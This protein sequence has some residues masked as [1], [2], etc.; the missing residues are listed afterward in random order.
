MG[1]LR[2]QCQQATFAT[3][4]LIGTHRP[5]VEDN[6]HR[7]GI[8]GSIGTMHSVIIKRVGAAMVL[9]ATSTRVALAQR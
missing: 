4:L 3:G 5:V 1:G 8:L 9:F 7:G 6:T 2:P